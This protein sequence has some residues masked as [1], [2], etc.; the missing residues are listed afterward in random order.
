MYIRIYNNK[1][2]KDPTKDQRNISERGLPFDLAEQLDWTTALIWED[3]RK[4]YGEPRYSVLGF[5]ENRLHSVVF[6]PRDGKVRVISLRKA[7]KREVKRYET[8]D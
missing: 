5:I 2:D 1:V 4:D 7:N 8:T 3:K 6:T